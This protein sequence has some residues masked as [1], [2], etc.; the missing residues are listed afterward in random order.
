MFSDFKMVMNDI[1]VTMHKDPAARSAIEVYFLYPHIK[2]LKSYRK[3]HRLY[4]N[5]HFFAARWI[6]QKV[7]KKTGIEIHPGAEIGDN[8]FIDHGMGVVIGETAV[9]GDNVTLYQGVTLGGTGKDQGKRHPTLGN[10]V[11][12]GSGAKILGNIYIAPGTKVGANAVV[13]KDTTHKS[14]AVGIP[15]RIIDSRTWYFNL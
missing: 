7:R 1:K 6:S 15:A 9:I 10:C 3:A 13:L 11:V 8:L 12:V 4:K 2:A 5:G 14:T